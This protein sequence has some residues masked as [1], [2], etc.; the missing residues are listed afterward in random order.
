MIGLV[1][2]SHSAKLAEGL[3]ELAGQM[4]RDVT[5]VPAGGTEEGIGTSF[6]KI[7]AAV[8]T[9]LESNEGVVLLSD[10]GSATMT[11]EMVLEF[12]DEP[13]RFVDAPFVEAAIAAAIAAQQGGDLETVAQAAAESITSFGANDSGGNESTKASGD[14]SRTAKVA[15]PTGLHARPAAQIAELASEAIDDVFLNDTEADSAL[16][17]MGLGIG[18]GDEVRISGSSADKSTIDAIADLIEQG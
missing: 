5:I 14:Y 15:D 3:A 1:L 4:A 2:V 7:D 12:R 11:V 6:D 9:A 8:S 13:L 10:L 18:H 16:M 17:V